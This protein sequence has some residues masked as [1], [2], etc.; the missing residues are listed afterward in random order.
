VQNTEQTQRYTRRSLAKVDK[1]KYSKLEWKAIK[2]QRRQDKA[3]GRLTKL[4]KAQKSVEIAQNIPQESVDKN[5]ILCLKHGTKYSADYVNNLYNGVKRHCTLDFEMVCLTDDPKG[6]NKDIKI[7]PLPGQLQ[8]WWCK[9]YMFS[10]DLPLKGTVLYM[11]LD[12]V[13]AS[14]IDKLFTWQLDRWCTIRDFT[15]AMRPKWQK[16]NSSIVR[17]RVGQLSHVWENYQADRINIE[18][19]LHG[20]QDWL[21]EATRNTQAVLYP[22]SWILSWKWEVR[23]TKD[24]KPGGLR[25]NRQFKTVENCKPKVECCVAVFHGDP[26]P[27]HCSDPWVVENWR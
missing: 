18:K 1:G 3:L 17:F 26:N 8:G 16:Y 21:Y 2:E 23:K 5:Y 9:P 27:A 4:D 14:N 15:R 12:V 25:G 13:I 19:R 20:D 10:K 22:D 11:D 6:I 24:F 7:L